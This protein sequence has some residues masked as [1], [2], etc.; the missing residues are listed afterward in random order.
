MKKVAYA[1]VTL[2]I[3]QKVIQSNSRL[4]VGLIIVTLIIIIGVIAPLITWYPPLKTLVNTPFTFP[5]LNNP[6]GTDDLGRDIYTNVVYGIRTSLLIGVL[7]TS[8]SLIIGIII[9]AIA[10]YRGGILGDILMRITDMAF[11]IPSFLLALLIATIIGPTIQNIIIAIGITSWPGVARM[12]RAEFLRIKERLFIEAAKASGVSDKRIILF[13]IMPNAMPSVIPYIT[14]QISNN[15]LIEAGL[16]FLGVG[17]PNVPSLGLMLNNAQEYLTSAWWLAF[18][19][20]LALSL[21]IIGF[22]LLGDGLIDYMNPRL[23]KI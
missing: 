14:L 9:G 6:F 13:H 12:T 11:I 3:A 10:G 21:I 16:S 20:G 4:Q 7:S 19:P 15:I 22:N 23:K 2:Q 5:N 1:D 17:D 18:F 8:L